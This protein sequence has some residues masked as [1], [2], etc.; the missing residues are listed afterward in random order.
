MIETYKKVLESFYQVAEQDYLISVSQ[1]FSHAIR[2]K[3]IHLVLMVEKFKKE[4]KNFST[5]LAEASMSSKSTFSNYLSVAEKNKFISRYRDH[6]NYKKMR[7]VLDT[8][9]EKLHRYV[10]QYYSDLYTF[11]KKSLDPLSLLSMAKSILLISNLF[12]TDEP[13]FKI[14][15]LKAPSF[16]DLVKALDRIFFSMHAKE[17]EFIDS[18]TLD[19]S[20][21]D[22]KVLSV[23]EILALSN[24]NK[25]KEIAEYAKIQFS[26]LSSILK[27][28]EKKQ[29]IRREESS[30]D[31]RVLKAFVLPVG[32]SISKDYM[33]VRLNIHNDIKENIKARNYEIMIEA[34]KLIKKFSNDYNKKST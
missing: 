13:K 11:L 25:P 24:Q 10:M 23:I 5:L 17:L 27:N 18:N 9:G 32:Q 1:S 29:Y 2:L 30:E 34:F 21:T 3:D 26:T 16:D 15:V 12:S 33:E 22:L 19:V 7:I 4:D 20:F 6:T 28:L 8:E 14:H 31:H